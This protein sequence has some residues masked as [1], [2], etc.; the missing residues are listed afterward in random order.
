MQ[1][2]EI[3]DGLDSKIKQYINDNNL[4]QVDHTNLNDSELLLK[5]Q[6]SFKETAMHI[7][8]VHQT[9]LKIVNDVLPFNT[10]SV[11]RFEQLLKNIG[12]LFSTDSIS[13]ESFNKSKDIKLFF[14]GKMHNEKDFF[15][16][17]F[18]KYS[19]F[20]RVIEESITISANSL[21][22]VEQPL[23]DDINVDFNLA[24]DEFINQISQVTGFVVDSNF[25]ENIDKTTMSERINNIFAQKSIQDIVYVD[26][27]DILTAMLL[28]KETSTFEVGVDDFSFSK[29]DHKT[30]FALLNQIFFNDC[31]DTLTKIITVVINYQKAMHREDKLSIGFPVNGRFYD[32]AKLPVINIYLNEKYQLGFSTNGYVF[33][34]NEVPQHV[35]DYKRLPE[36][37]NKILEESERHIE[38]EKLTKQLI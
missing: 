33:T 13:L 35:K 2:K 19:I 26:K 37:L 15:A 10:A 5:N 16:I 34:N 14:F 1:F 38:R 12:C 31:Y 24:L 22:T 20:I 3:Y 29:E 9:S 21:L 28:Y 18:K 23:S 7:Y 17:S 4:Q 36:V 30:M 6:F 11:F 27:S 25:Q 32:T 8:C